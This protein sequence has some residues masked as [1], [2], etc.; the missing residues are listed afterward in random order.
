MGCNCKVNQQIDYMHR[1]YGN[2]LPVSKKTEISFRIK[3]K[4]REFLVFLIS[5]I[6]L[7]LMVLSV[8]YKTLFTK[9]KKISIRKIMKFANV[10]N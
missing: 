9:D 3:E 5:L 10:R 2:K 1:K 7:P 8:L 4:A 6:F